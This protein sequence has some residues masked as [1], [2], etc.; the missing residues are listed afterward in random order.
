M[1]DSYGE[2]AAEKKRRRIDTEEEQLYI[3]KEPA[4]NAV[5][6]VGRQKESGGESEE[7]SGSAGEME[8][9]GRG[10][11]TL[12]H[13]YSR[14]FRPFPPRRCPGPLE[15]VCRAD[16]SASISRG[17]RQPAA[18][19][20]PPRAYAP[21]RGRREPREQGVR[22]PC[23]VRTSSPGEVYV[24]FE[25]AAVELGIGADKSAMARLE[26]ASER[27]LRTPTSP[28]LDTAAAAVRRGLQRIPE[29]VNARAGG[30]RAVR[31][32]RAGD[33]RKSGKAGG[34]GSRSGLSSI[35]KSRAAARLDTLQQA[36]VSTPLSFYGTAYTEPTS[37]PNLRTIRGH[38]AR[39]RLVAAAAAR[40]TVCE[41]YRRCRRPR[42][43]WR[44]GDA[45]TLAADL[46]VRGDDVLVF[47]M[48]T[49]FRPHWRPMPLGG[50][51]TWRGARR[52][53]AQ[54][55]RGDKES[56][57]GPSGGVRRTPW[58]ARRYMIARIATETWLAP[59]SAQ[60]AS[61]SP[62]RGFTKWC[63]YARRC[64]LAGIATEGVVSEAYTQTKAGT[65]TRARGRHRSR[66]AA[67]LAALVAKLVVECTTIS[68]TSATDVRPSRSVSAAKRQVRYGAGR[69]APPHRERTADDQSRPRHPLLPPRCCGTEAWLR[70]HVVK[71][72]FG[73]LRIKGNKRKASER[74][75]ASAQTVE[76]ETSRNIA[77][78]GL[79][80]L[81]HLRLIRWKDQ[82]SD[83][84][85]LQ[86]NQVH[87]MNRVKSYTAL[88]IN[89]L[90]H[91]E[92]SFMA[93]APGWRVPAYLRTPSRHSNA[94]EPRKV[95]WDS[96]KARRRESPSIEISAK[97]TSVTM[98]RE[99]E[100]DT[101]AGS[102]FDSS[103]GHSGS[104]L[105]LHSHPLS[106]FTESTLADA[107]CSSNL[108]SVE[109]WRQVKF[110]ARKTWKRGAHLHL[111]NDSGMGISRELVR[112][113]PGPFAM[114]LTTQG[115]SIHG[116]EGPG[117]L[118][119]RSD[120]SPG[121]SSVRIFVT[122]APDIR[123]RVEI[124]LGKARMRCRNS[125]LLEQRI[126]NSRLSLRCEGYKASRRAV[127]S[128]T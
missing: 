121:H 55:R 66:P 39:C 95:G 42:Q 21:Y 57:G 90:E 17:Q 63:A 34:V 114:L 88:P 22:Y 59:D 125:P 98:G 3:G 96:G 50:V 77:E 26:T 93:R 113:E 76:V 91:R 81:A 2:F 56:G 9:V 5:S 31:T 48:R 80:A 119:A 72:E 43:S 94:R 123:A 28:T 92:V 45:V 75:A 117:A 110:E 103:L 18:T 87:V 29:L 116:S 70:C 128:C 118:R 68:Q 40:P 100:S 109:N 111:M 11:R 71:S 89:S 27:G 120:S 16:A 82:G 14:P 1:S 64:V 33:E 62:R 115:G 54:R 41:Q 67:I 58:R 99:S 78:Q 47:V 52:R 86:A 112:L 15:S 106:F 25:E 44:G 79:E 102:S 20:S 60:L 6:Q 105:A 38:G 53:S 101:L 4:S 51:R 7:A 30:R 85:N 84:S 32:G 19:T 122:L 104:I 46:G 69:H 65:G 108:A 83:D 107:N 97:P 35:P 126:P 10:E 49:R 61:L 8:R 36:P 127:R 24:V 12:E 37:M 13:T 23:G 74:R 124:Q 73:V